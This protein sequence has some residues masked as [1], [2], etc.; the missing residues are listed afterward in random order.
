MTSKQ[1]LPKLSL[2]AKTLLG[3]DDKTRVVDR[4]YDTPCREWMGW[5]S[6][7][8]YGDLYVELK[9]QR[10]HR[11]CWEMYH[12]KIP[13][14]WC[15]CHECDNRRCVNPHHL[16]LGTN[17]DNVQ[18]RHRKGRSSSSRGET[19]R[20]CKLTTQKVISI[21]NE[22]QTVKSYRVLARK[23]GVE[24]TNIANIIKRKTWKHV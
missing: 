1:R 13:D 23:Y 21:R 7:K 11:F 9:H 17:Y 10:A 4:G 6:N 12:G 19:Q 3:F 14:G 5:L 8:G 18:D 22:Y 16:F 20:S 24:Y 2:F 15:V